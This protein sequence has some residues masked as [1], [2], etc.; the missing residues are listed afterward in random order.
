MHRGA[1]SLSL[2]ALLSVAARAGAQ[3]P[4]P[5]PSGAPTPTQETEPTAPPSTTHLRLEEAERADSGRGLAFF[6]L[7]PEVGF[8][9][10]HLLDTSVFDGTTIPKDSYGLAV[11]AG[12]GVRLL[13]FTLGARFDYGVLSAWDMWSLDLEVALRVPLGD[14]E[15][16]VG[17]GGGFV[18]L[19]GATNVAS[20]SGAQFGLHGGLDYFVTHVFSVGVRVAADFLVVGRGPLTSSGVVAPPF[21]DGASGAG[22]SYTPSVVLGLHL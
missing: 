18:S 3:L 22:L 20:A 14:W 8:R 15:P 11:G 9:G 7:E 17:L 21:V 4:P 13:Y 16:Y 10:V 19:D 6:W 2:L 5:Q 1:S 12:A